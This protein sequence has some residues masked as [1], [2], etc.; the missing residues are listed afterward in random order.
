MF[1]AEDIEK[2]IGVVN[3][4]YS[5]LIVTTLGTEALSEYDRAILELNGVDVDALKQDYPPFM[6]MFMLGRLAAILDDKQIQQLERDDFNKYLERG[7]FVPL[8]QREREEYQISQ[9][10]SYGHL[11]GLANKVT[12]EARDIIL[13]ENKKLIISEEITRGAT[14]RLSIQSIVSN[15]GHRTGE[16]DRDWRR[17]VVTEMQNIYNQGKAGEI[18]QKYGDEALV[19]KQVFEGACRHC[20]RLYTT[21]G[22]G[23]EPRV[24]KLKDLIANGNNLNLKVD[25][26]KPI[27]GATHSHCRCDLRTVFKGQVWNLV[28]KVWGYVDGRV[29]IVQRKSKI[30]ITVGDKEFFV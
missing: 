25:E 18:S 27:V 22:L 15:L 30:K 17:I 20:I 13:E 28:D 9:Q 26:W 6:Q 21:S 14:D 2:V 12:S 11:K 1:T 29:G 10:M 5:M 19:W 24:F 8:S 16:W 3:R 4:H 23:S 7:Q